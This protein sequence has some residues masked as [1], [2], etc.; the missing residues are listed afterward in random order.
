MINILNKGPYFKGPQGALYYYFVCLVLMEARAD[1]LREAVAN[2]MAG[3]DE[4]LSE[5][6]DMASA[7]ADWQVRSGSWAYNLLD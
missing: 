7:I 3:V 6:S 2:A 4:D 5:D 1:R